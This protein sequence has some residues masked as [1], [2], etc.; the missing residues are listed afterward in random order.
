M[1]GIY[2]LDVLFSLILIFIA[3][4]AVLLILERFG[5]GS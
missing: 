3:Y 1:T 4:A 2:V 5:G